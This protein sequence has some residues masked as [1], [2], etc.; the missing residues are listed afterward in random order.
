MLSVVFWYCKMNLLLLFS[1]FL[2]K[3]KCILYITGMS[4]ATCLTVSTT[5]AG[6]SAS[7]SVD[8]SHR[9]D[10]GTI[11]DA[12]AQDILMSVIKHTCTTPFDNKCEHTA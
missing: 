1:E 3:M 12:Y 7:P 4:A 2:V 6:A 9:E 8:D 5:A 11:R 10:Q